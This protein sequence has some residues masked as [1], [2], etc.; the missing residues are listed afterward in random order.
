MAHPERTRKDVLRFAICRTYD[1]TIISY[2]RLLCACKA[3]KCFTGLPSGAIR[4]Y[5]N[6]A[7]PSSLSSKMRRC[8]KSLPSFACE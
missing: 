4:M 8:H 3:C 5:F 1:A 7:E 6:G 2:V